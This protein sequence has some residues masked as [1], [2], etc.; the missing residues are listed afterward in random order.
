MLTSG[1]CY[2][3]ITD[4]DAEACAVGGASSER[5]EYKL[6]V[7]CNTEW[8]GISCPAPTNIRYQYEPSRAFILL[9]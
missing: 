5:V 7:V 9:A 3:P 1:S 6:I 8:A 4:N 2:S